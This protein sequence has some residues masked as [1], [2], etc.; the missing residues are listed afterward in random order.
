M[1]NLDG[2]AEQENYYN[3]TMKEKKNLIVNIL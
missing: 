3:N 1:N 2:S